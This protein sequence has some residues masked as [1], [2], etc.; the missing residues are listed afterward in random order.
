MPNCL[1]CQDLKC[2]AAEHS[3]SRDG[4]VLDLLGA[5]IES[6][7]ATIPMVGGGQGRAKPD[8][9]CMPGWKEQ[10]AP[11]RKDSLVW[12][13]LAECREAQQGTTL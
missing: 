11:Q 13:C 4:F 7:H 3:D 6:S 2:K 5:V 1:H 9:G 12:Q 8:S 10:V